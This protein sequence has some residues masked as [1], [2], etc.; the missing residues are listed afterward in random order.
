MNRIHRGAGR[1]VQS[2]IIYQYLAISQKWCKVG[3]QPLQQ[4]SSWMTGQFLQYKR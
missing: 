1:L 3:T 4:I 2:A